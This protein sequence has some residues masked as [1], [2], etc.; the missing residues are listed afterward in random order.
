M[1][2]NLLS[3]IRHCYMNSFTN[4]TTGRL[5]EGYRLVLEDFTSRVKSPEV[6]ISDE[7]V[8]RLNLL[9]PKNN[10]YKEPI[11]KINGEWSVRYDGFKF[12]YSFTAQDIKL[13]NEPKID[14]D[15]DKKKE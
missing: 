15:K 3:P 9:D 11:L 14:I 5:F 8:K 6:N 4:K 13:I 2:G 12:M 7:C 1:I 10:L